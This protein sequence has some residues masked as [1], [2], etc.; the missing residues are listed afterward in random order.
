MDSLRLAIWTLCYHLLSYVIAPDFGTPY[1]FVQSHVTLGTTPAVA[2]G[3]VGRPL[4]IEELMGN[5]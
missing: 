2:S 4:T 1:N 3:L 5:Q